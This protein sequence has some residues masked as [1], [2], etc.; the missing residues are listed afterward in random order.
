MLRRGFSL[1]LVLIPGLAFA[2]VSM[3]FSV[4]EV[5]VNVAPPPMRVEVQPPRPS[6]NHIWIAGHWAWRAG[7]HVW[8]GGHWAMPPGAGYVWEPARWIP[9]PN[10]GYRFVEGHWRW[11]G[12]YNPTAVYEPAAPAGEVI[13]QTPPPANIVEV[14]PAV[15]FA[16]AVW[17]P[18]YWNWNGATHIWVAGRWSAPRPG[19]AWEPHHWARMPNGG[20]RMEHGHWRRL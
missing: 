6:P 10:G 12:T 14:R 16:G 18:G 13:V 20:W 5:S 15:P 7:A 9:Q 4:P 8:I 11:G 17:I 19:F 2:Q 3:S 1:A